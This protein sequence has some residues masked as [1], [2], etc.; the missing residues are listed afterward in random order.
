VSQHLS[1]L[2][3]AGAVHPVR[4]GPEVLYLLTDRGHRLLEI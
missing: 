3:G 4:Q 1:A 2:T